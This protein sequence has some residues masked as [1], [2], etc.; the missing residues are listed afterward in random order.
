[1][2]GSIPITWTEKVRSEGAAE[3]FFIGRR[4]RA[5]PPEGCIVFS[6]G[7][8]MVCSDLVAWAEK[9]RGEMENIYYVSAGVV[10]LWGLW[11]LRT[12]AAK[13]K[14]T[15]PTFTL[16][17]DITIKSAPLYSEAE[18]TLYNLLRMV[19][20]DRY[21]VLSQVPLWAF[22]SVEG[23]GKGRSQVLNHMALKHV[24][25]VLVHPGSRQV[26]QVVQVD[27]ETQR[28]HQEERQRIIT[29]I[30]DAA[31]IKV[32]TIEAK[33]NYSIPDLTELLGLTPEE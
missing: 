20:Q 25:F 13:R 2:V 29:T 12:R 30:L 6:G 5:F 22:V 1:M 19:V 7:P 21:L 10:T 27:D 9:E 8:M 14:R 4:H 26:E 28:P 24:D 17:S 16:P 11:R 23:I 33:K 31:G 32:L 3:R 15:L 18:A